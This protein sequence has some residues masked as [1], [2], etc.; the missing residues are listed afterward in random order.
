MDLIFDPTRNSSSA[1]A[2][3]YLLMDAQ[4]SGTSLF[5][6]KKKKTSGTRVLDIKSNSGKKKEKN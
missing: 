2:C 4:T 3:L 5:K 1:P 6:K